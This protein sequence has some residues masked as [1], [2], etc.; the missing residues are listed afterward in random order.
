VSNEVNKRIHDAV[1]EEKEHYDSLLEGIDTFLEVKERV[2][3]SFVG[4]IDYS[5]ID[6]LLA[7]YYVSLIGDK[8]SDYYTEEEL[9]SYSNK[10]SASFVG[11]GVAC[12]EQN[13][14]IHVERVLENSPALDA[15]IVPGDNIISV[16]GVKVTADNYSEVTNAFIGEKG[17]TV[18]FEIE[19]KNGKI[20][21]VEVERREIITRTI[22]SE[23]LEGNI[24]YV[25][26]KQFATNTDKEFIEAVDSLLADGA[27]RF[28]FDVR[29]NSGGNLNCVVN[30]LDR[31]LPKG[32][33]VNIVYGDEK[34]ET[35]YSTDAKSISLPM[36]V[37]INKKTAS[38]SE[39][40]ASALRDYEMATLYGKNTYGKGYMQ[41][42][43]TLSDN[44]GLKLSIAKYNPPYGENYEGIGVSPHVDVDDIPTT[45]V[46]EQLEMAK[47]F[48]KNQN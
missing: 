42:I 38:A 7:D 19:S 3:Q 29:D 18:T 48:L 25:K 2:D 41:R 35:L 9:Q 39:L 17:T 6:G 20:R 37:L 27:K 11:I 47:D 33:I 23:M 4:D 1:K 30:I 13:G 10:L 16:D 15:G 22:Y 14:K 24:G 26:I 34:T 12:T 32:P 36:A 46:D 40:F 8:Y 21:K 44:S 43:F 5:K 45:S 28:L 31:L